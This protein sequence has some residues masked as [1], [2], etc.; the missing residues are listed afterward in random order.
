MP[1]RPVVQVDKTPTPIK[2]PVKDAVPPVKATPKDEPKATES[3]TPT[4]GSNP[5]KEAIVQTSSVWVWTTVE[6]KTPVNPVLE[7]EKKC[8]T[9]KGNSE[10][11]IG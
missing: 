8:Y 4:I 10:Y 7:S 2:P 9:S 3:I 5:V 1:I 6:I 11:H